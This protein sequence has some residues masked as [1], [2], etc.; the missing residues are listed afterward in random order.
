M[1]QHSCL[2]SRVQDFLDDCVWVFEVFGRDGVE[3]IAGGG[4]EGVFFFEASRLFELL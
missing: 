4:N 2:C 1:H 3:G